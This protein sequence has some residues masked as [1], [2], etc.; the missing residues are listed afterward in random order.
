VGI[1]YKKQYESF[2]EMLN[3]FNDIFKY[4]RK[5]NLLK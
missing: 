1:T 2:E 4:K 3:G 5:S